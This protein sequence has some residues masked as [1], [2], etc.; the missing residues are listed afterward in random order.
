M[1]FKEKG[2]E[3]IIIKIDKWNKNFESFDSFYLILFSIYVFFS[4]F[5]YKFEILVYQKLK[6]KYHLI[7]LAI[8]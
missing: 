5:S 8:N 3:D 6:S 2:E 7:V 4:F 1:R